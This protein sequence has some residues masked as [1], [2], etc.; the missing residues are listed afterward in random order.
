MKRLLLLVTLFV[1]GIGIVSADILK[2]QA[3]SLAYKSAN[4]YGVWSEWSDWESCSI[5]V[6]INTDQDRINIYSSTPQEYDIYDYEG[7]SHDRDGGTTNTLKC[8]DAN[9]LR[10]E[11][12]LRQQRNG[13]WQLYVDYNDFMFVYNI[14]RK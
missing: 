9:G 10:C 3:T 11:M 2:L 8:I 13:S 5:L 1:F 4:D 6:V 12:R 14:E 7:E